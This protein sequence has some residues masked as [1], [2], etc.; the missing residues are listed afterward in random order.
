MVCL[1]NSR[2]PGGRCVAGREV[3]KDAYGG[4]IRPVSKRASAEVSLD[5][6]RYEDGTD[7]QILDVV[8]VPMIDPVPKG[9]QTENHMLDDEY[10][11]TKK[12]SIKWADLSSLVETPETLWTNGVST[13]HGIND[14]VAAASAA[15]LTSSLALIQ[16]STVSIVVQVEGGMFGPAKKRVRAEF[17]YNGALYRFMVTDPHVEQIFLAREGAFKMEGAYLCVS[18]TEPFSG[19]GR[20]HKLVATMITKKPLE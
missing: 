20:C 10:Y 16:P 13:Y 15:G 18:L 9:H 19:D 4:W 3:L 1:A 17:K 11:W 8:R 12:S 7:P 5:E 2:K 14:C 6:R